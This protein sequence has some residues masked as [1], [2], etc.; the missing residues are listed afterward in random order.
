MGAPR[1]PASSS[2]GRIGLSME[3][4]TPTRILPKAPAKMSLPVELLQEIVDFMPVQTQL[5]F[6]RTSHAMRDM[7]YDDSRWVAKLKAMGAWNEEDARRHAEEEITRRR[8]QKQRAQ[9]EAIL[10]RALTNGVTTTTLFDAT[11]E[12]KKTAA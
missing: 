10:G 8:E 3:V 9:A 1:E 2:R 6:A 7:I 11:L 5:T 12:A 4:L